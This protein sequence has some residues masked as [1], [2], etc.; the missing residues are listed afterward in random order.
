MFI[1]LYYLI[2]YRIK[3]KGDGPGEGVHAEA[4]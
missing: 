4:G 2:I 3:A 1:L